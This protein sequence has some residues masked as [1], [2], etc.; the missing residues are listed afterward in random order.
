MNQRRDP[1]MDGAFEKTTPVDPLF[2][3][4]SNPIGSGPVDLRSR[5]A[6]QK[7][8]LATNREVETITRQS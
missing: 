5:T 2:Q 1:M 7:L 8:V 6:Q 4:F 3:K